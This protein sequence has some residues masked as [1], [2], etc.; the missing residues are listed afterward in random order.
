VRYRGDIDHVP[1]ALGTSCL[2]RLTGG[3][4]VSLNM[5]RR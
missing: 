3:H 4:V 5:A 2:H 1:A